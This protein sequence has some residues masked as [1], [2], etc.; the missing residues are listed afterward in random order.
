MLESLRGPLKPFTD[1]LGKTFSWLHPNTISIIGFFLGFIPAYFYYTNRPVIGGVWMIILLFDTIDGAVARYTGKVSKFGEVL[2]ASLDRITDGLIIFSIAF[3]GY[4]SWYLAFISLI[5]FYLV[6]YVRARTGEAAAKEVKLNVGIA[7]RGERIILIAIASLLY[8]SKI[9]IP[10]IGKSVNSL[11][12][13]F[14]LLSILTWETT[15]HR[16]IVAYKKLKE[17]ES[18]GKKI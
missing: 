7:Q 15:I 2:D 4:I 14:V 9:F 10:F 13:I 18:N 12:L 17:L 5:G 8:K 16:L 3:G 11:E 6:S 1:F